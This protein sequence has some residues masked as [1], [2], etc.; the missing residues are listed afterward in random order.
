MTC[1]V[2]PVMAVP[3]TNSRS[4]DQNNLFLNFSMIS[5]MMRPEMTGWIS[6]AARESEEGARRPVVDQAADEDVG[7]S[8]D[9][10]YLPRALLSARPS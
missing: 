7:V 10:H 4:S 8:G 9:A 2:V 1:S 6:P 5:S 3:A